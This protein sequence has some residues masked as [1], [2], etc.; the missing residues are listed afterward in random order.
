MNIEQRTEHFE[1]STPLAER[2]FNTLPKRLVSG[3]YAQYMAK[4]FGGLTLGELQFK[5]SNETESIME[6][7]IYS[8]IQGGKDEELLTPAYFAYNFDTDA[9]PS[10]RFTNDVYLEYFNHVMKTKDKRIKVLGYTARLEPL[11]SGSIRVYD[12]KEGKSPIPSPE[13]IGWI[14]AE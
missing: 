11:I 9:S 2:F 14:T 4:L 13:E 1:I 5:L 3:T 7:L 12:I 10:S 8:A 6:G